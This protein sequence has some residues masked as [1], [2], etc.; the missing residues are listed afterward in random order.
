MSDRLFYFIV[1][2]IILGVTAL[3]VYLY[4]NI[5]T[6]NRGLSAAYSYLEY[7]LIYEYGW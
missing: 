1:V 7:A 4:H 5:T 3:I 2:L 6:H